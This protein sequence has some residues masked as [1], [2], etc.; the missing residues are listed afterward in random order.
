LQTLLPPQIQQSLNKETDIPPEIQQ[1]MQ[2]AEQ[3]MQQVQQYGQ[4]VQE[5]NAELEQSKS[6]A[7]KQ[8]A[9]IKTELANVRAAKAEFDA[10]VAEVVGGLSEKK[11]D[12]ITRAAGMLV[13]ETEVGEAVDSRVQ[14]DFTGDIDNILA[15][16]MQAVDQAMGRMDQNTSALHSRVNRKPIGG[17]TRREGG[18]LVANVQFDDGSEENIAAERGPAGLRIVPDTEG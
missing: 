10:H 15:G 17:E 3:A 5:A 9:E 11:A 7:E 14:M 4:L 16:F 12:L 1:M 18:R 6:E 2:Q 8:K 13:R